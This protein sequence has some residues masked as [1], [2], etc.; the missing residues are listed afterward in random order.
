MYIIWINNQKKT[1][2]NIYKKYIHKG[3]KKQKKT[4]A[5]D[6]KHKK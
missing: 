5:K 6:K 3:N 1:F 4:K 2:K